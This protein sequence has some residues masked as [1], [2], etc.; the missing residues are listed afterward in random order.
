MATIRNKSASPAT[1]D[2]TRRGSGGGATTR[3]TGT[4]RGG[5]EQE[6][7]GGGKSHGLVK[8]DA[9][10][11]HALPER[12]A[13]LPKDHPERKRYEKG[14]KADDLQYAEA[15]AGKGGFSL[16][17]EL[18]WRTL[19]PLVYLLVILV[20]L[21]GGGWYVHQVLETR[22][23]IWY[24]IHAKGW[25]GTEPIIRRKFDR[26]DKSWWLPTLQRLLISARYLIKRPKILEDFGGRN[27]TLESYLRHIMENDLPFNEEEAIRWLANSYR[28]PARTVEESPP[29]SPAAEGDEGGR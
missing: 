8:F 10:K 14:W 27:P 25:E 3:G 4:T 9:K 28:F 6:G 11:A 20:G 19:K 12:I 29:V 1:S 21:G 23:A 24:T 13:K 16:V 15:Q 18:D 5:K 17:A 26:V 22:E 7:A 2:A